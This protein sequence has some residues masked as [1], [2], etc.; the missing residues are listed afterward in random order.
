MVQIYQSQQA[1]EQADLRNIYSL[2]NME[3][4]EYGGPADSGAITACGAAHQPLAALAQQHFI[5]I[6]I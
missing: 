2:T 4:S 1:S 6:A 3:G 5:H